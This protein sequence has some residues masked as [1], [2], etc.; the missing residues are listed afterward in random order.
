MAT[1]LRQIQK[2]PVQALPPLRD[3]LA[4]NAVSACNLS[5][6]ITTLRFSH[7]L[8]DVSDIVG[9]AGHG[10][11]WQ[12]ALTPF[13][14]VAADQ[15]DGDPAVALRRLQSSPYQRARQLQSGAA[16]SAATAAIKDCRELLVV[17]LL[18]GEQASI[19]VT[20]QLQYVHH[21]VRPQRLRG[22]CLP[23][24]LLLYWLVSSRRRNWQRRAPRRTPVDGRRCCGQAA[25]AARGDHPNQQPLLLCCANIRLAHN[26]WDKRYALAPTRPQVRNDG[27]G[28][29]VLYL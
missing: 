11:Q 16:T 9:L 6:T 24:P 4:R 8:K 27:V 22:Y 17:Q 14:V 10:L 20:V 12:R 23:E 28:F 25:Q 1:Q 7:R 21:H 19:T 13:A 2:A 3:A 15:P 5:E 18:A 29:F 26:T